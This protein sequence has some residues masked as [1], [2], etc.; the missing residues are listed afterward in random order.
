MH[1]PEPRQNTPPNTYRIQKPHF[2]TGRGGERTPIHQKRKKRPPPPQR[3]I[4]Q[5]VDEDSKKRKKSSTNL[6]AEL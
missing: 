1:Q 6:N 5:Q 3:R 4:R 2:S